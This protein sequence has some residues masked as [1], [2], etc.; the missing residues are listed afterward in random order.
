[1]AFIN[2]KTY[3][4]YVEENKE[5]EFH[6][7]FEKAL[8][9]VE[10]GKEYPILI[11]KDQIKLNSKFTVK[12]PIDTSI[13]LGIFQKDDGNK[14]DEAIKIAKEAF[15]YWKNSDWIDRVELAHKAV[16]EI[17]RRKFELGAIITYENGKNRY[18]AMGEVDEAIDYFEYYTKILEDNRGF[19]REMESRIVK[20]EKAYSVMRPYGTW[21]IIS[22]FNFP[23]AITTTMTLGALLTG[24]TVV[25]KPSSDT[26]IS[27][28]MLVSILR[29]AGFPPEVV[30]YVTI[31]GE[32]IEKHLTIDGFAFTGSKE[33]GH[34]LLKKFINEKPR[35]AVLELGG[36]NAT[37]ITEKADLQ[38]AIEGTYRGAFGFGGQ[39]CSATSRIFIQSSI[40][41]EALIKL[42]EKIENTKIGDPRERNTFLGP[43]IN[44]NAVEK[45]K[46][47]LKQIQSE[48]GKIL[49]GGKVIEEEKSYL[50]E[51]TVIVDLPYSSPLWKTEFFVP[52]VLAKEFKK[53]EEAIKMANDVDYGLTAGIFSEDEKEIQ[54]FFEN[55][56]AGVTYANRIYGSTTGAM[57]GVQPFGGWKDS[58]YTGKNAGGP[59]YLLSFLREQARTT[60]YEEK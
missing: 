50:V 45:Y 42:K 38:K 55:I 4:N 8:K 5:E 33:V 32:L 21:L 58:G 23:L 2:E 57:P 46:N 11:G 9:S 19:I 30:N 22:P 26:P 6:R 12:T 40:Y 31:S 27:A 54:Y 3:Q 13:T 56:E 20:N 25:V 34:R 37:I 39:K 15:S 36:K 51:P 35:P 47:Y 60:Y 10:L 44:K 43:V 52:I 49:V 24:N 41:D 29:K 1:M 7:E 14:L 17:R 59:Y 18:E 53:L 28:Y 48:G 16:N